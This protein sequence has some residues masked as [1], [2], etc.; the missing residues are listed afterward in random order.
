MKNQRKKYAILY[1][2]GLLN[3][4]HKKVISEII[5]SSKRYSVVA[6]IDSEIPDQKTGFFNTELG[7]DI[8]A[9]SDIGTCI[10]SMDNAGIKV[11]NFVIGIID[12]FMKIDERIMKCINDGIRHGLN[13]DSGLFDKLI[14]NSR[15]KEISR[16]RGIII[17]EIRH[18]FS[19]NHDNLSDENLEKVQSVIIAVIGTDKEAENRTTSIT[20]KELIEE[21]GYKSEVIGTSIVSWLLGIDKCRF[22]NSMT[23]EFIPS[24]IQK[25]IYSI[26]KEEKPH[27]ILIEGNGSLLSPSY[28]G[29]HELLT[30]IK[31]DIIVLQYD[32]NRTFYYGTQE[33]LIHSIQRQKK[34]IEIIS[35]K[36]VSGIVTSIRNSEQGKLENLIQRVKLESDIPVYDMS[37]ASSRRLVKYL[38][39]VSGRLSY[40]KIRFQRRTINV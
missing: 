16:E 8:K 2:E 4:E 38:F 27:F 31:P 17:N 37:L 15:Q 35:G 34:A 14:L 39:N 1:C 21:E 32:P 3:S 18:G 28:P 20:I 5:S 23:K 12:E 10:I 7:L 19:L 26:W 29:S 24:A 36:S 30:C 25:Q 40:K 6:V 33:S 22:L 11:Q 9:Y 13:I